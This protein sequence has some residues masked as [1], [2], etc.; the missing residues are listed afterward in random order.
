MKFEGEAHVNNIEI[1][2]VN[3]PETEIQLI[4]RNSLPPPIKTALTKQKSPLLLG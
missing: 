4:Q 1:E 2:S 3:D